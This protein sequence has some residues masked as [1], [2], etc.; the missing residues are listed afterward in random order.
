MCAQASHGVR[1]HDLPFARLSPTDSF[2]ARPDSASVMYDG[3]SD[4][5]LGVPATQR[6]SSSVSDN[7]EDTAAVWQKA[8]NG[9]QFEKA[10]IDKNE[11]PTL[12][13]QAAH[14]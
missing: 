4:Q 7:Y 1:P 6:R 13:S 9:Y 14:P 2:A 5:H 3:Q 11:S 8:L 12:S 10:M